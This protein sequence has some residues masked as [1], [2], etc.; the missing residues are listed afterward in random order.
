MCI[1]E[2]GRKLCRDWTFS[3]VFFM[4]HLQQRPWFC[5]YR[6]SV[7]AKVLHR[8]NHVLPPK[9][10]TWF[11]PGYLRL[12]GSRHGPCISI[13]TSPTTPSL[14]VSIHPGLHPYLTLPAI[15]GPGHRHLLPFYFSRRNS[16]EGGF[17]VQCTSRPSRLRFRRA[18]RTLAS[19]MKTVGIPIKLLHE[20]EGHE[21]MVRGT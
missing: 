12:F 2:Q 11:G 1:L 8:W 13:T 3:E 18:R 14:L 6:C 16:H 17:D 15:L 21:V 5:S 9:P 4:I 7:F 10:R 19:T 20:A